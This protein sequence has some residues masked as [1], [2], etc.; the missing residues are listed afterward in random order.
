MSAAE[1][2]PDEPLRCFL[3]EAV[4]ALTS[5]TSAPE[6]LV[7]GQEA[8]V[9]PLLAAVHRLKGAAALHGFPELVK[10]VGLAEEALQR[11]SGVSDDVCGRTDEFLGELI[12]GLRMVV[13]GIGA[14]G[15]EDAEAIARISVRASEMPPRAASEPPVLPSTSD[16]VAAPVPASAPTIRSET[17]RFQSTRDDPPEYFNVEASEHLD[18]IATALIAL[19][20][21]GRSDE[22][23]ATLFRAVHTLKGAAYVIGFGTLG[24]V[25]H[26]LEEVLSAVREA[27]IGL[28]PPVIEALFAGVSALRALL[29]ADEGPTEK[30]LDTFA[31]AMALL[32]SPTGTSQPP[33]L[34]PTRPRVPAV[35]VTRPPASP[36]P[37]GSVPIGASAPSLGRL[38]IRVT[39]ER[40]DAL[41]NLTAELVI[42]R[43]R[44]DR[45]LLRFAHLAELQS[46]SLARIGSVAKD[47]GRERQ[48]GRPP[49]GAR[50]DGAHDLLIDGVAGPVAELEIDRDEHLDVLSR[51]LTEIAADLSE[52]QSAFATAVRMVLADAASLQRLT[53]RL[54]GEITRARMIP[55]GT[56]FGRFGPLVREAAR[57]A[58]KDVR[59][60]VSGESVAVDTAIIEQIS[61]PLLHL[62]QN[63]I[64][65]GLE[66]KE[67]RCTRGKSPHGTVRLSAHHQAGFICFEVDDDGR[68]IDVA[69][70]KAQAVQQGFLDAAVAARLADFEALDLIF[71][72][73]LSTAPLVT[74]V[75]GRGVGMDVVRT[76]VARLN[77]Q[78]TVETEAGAGT[79]FT[80]KL[81]LTVASSEVLLV[82]VGSEILG[83][84][85]RAVQRV[86]TV[87]PET[88]ES[89]DG[90]ERLRVGEELV[91]AVRLE[92]VLDLS[93][94]KATPEL[95][96]VV[97]RA[98]GRAWAVL[99]TELLGQEDSVIKP[100]G[101]FL[102]GVGPWAGAM[103]SAE[104]RIILLVDPARLVEHREADFRAMATG[105]A[106]ALA[107]EPSLAVASPSRE[108]R[109]LLLVD[110]SISVRKVVGHMLEKAGFQVV[111]A[112]DGAEALERLSE[113]S[114]HAVIT[115]L[116]M[117]R[118]N[119]FQLIQDLRRRPATR[120]IPVVVLTTRAGAQH[121]NLARWLGVEHYLS[122]PV[123]EAV[124]VRLIDSLASSAVAGAPRGA[125]ETVGTP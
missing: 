11:A 53:G 48:N 37:S 77:G 90:I 26:Q 20:Q 55:I 98:R 116:E 86:L 42:T 122:K 17:R 78:V 27:Q 121:L 33:L 108:A 6:G 103:I 125:A 62:V 82:R 32:G 23:L 14:T 65:H 24:D 51:R 91:E 13:D 106:S 2:D 72:P 54:R 12:T 102:E 64:A 15:Q 69:R 111:T 74:M 85:L 114:F 52:V 34:E 109:R 9:E 28:T 47:I 76:N 63:A 21:R 29:A 50:L 75:A 105:T 97:L 7:G 71:L 73:G 66:S 1:R 56:L 95:S 67:E 8:M 115:D 44:L 10:L 58:G 68:G 45:H 5:L 110:D 61:D 80:L 40:L 99:V 79:R 16:E 112:S 3:V 93:P 120:D 36:A 30:S 100:L 101:S 22:E 92:R 70:L 31:R 19:E 81:P 117:P 4:A 118:L 49:Q 107:E 35:P 41:M 39:P 113:V 124:F 38:G 18:T 89:L 123:D 84:P 25:A 83:I 119:G 88:I 104:G 59:L 57:A 87:G 94:A 96:V 46:A 60:Q 43:N